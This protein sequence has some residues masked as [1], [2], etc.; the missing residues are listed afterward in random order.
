MFPAHAAP[1]HIARRNKRVE[2]FSLLPV[3]NEVD[4]YNEDFDM[5]KCQH[6]IKHDDTNEKKRK[7]LPERGGGPGVWPAG[8]S[9]LSFLIFCY[10]FIKKK[11]VAPAA[12]SGKD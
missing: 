9:I 6:S 8:G 7:G 11:V 3:K 12:M 4:K 1:W 10:F 2:F 5:L